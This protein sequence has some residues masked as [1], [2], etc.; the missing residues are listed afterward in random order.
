MASWD[1]LVCDCLASSDWLMSCI[2]IPGF[3]WRSVCY[4]S[5]SVCIVFMLIHVCMENF[6]TTWLVRGTVIL[7]ESFEVEGVIKNCSCGIE[8]F[9]CVLVHKNGE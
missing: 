2:I 6:S 1:W 5:V 3:V 8:F 9:C 4:A 7:K